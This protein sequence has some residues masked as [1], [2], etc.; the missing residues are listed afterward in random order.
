MLSLGVLQGCGN[1]LFY[2]PSTPETVHPDMR[3][4]SSTSGNQLA[5]RWLVTDSLNPKGIVLHFH[6]NSGHMD[7][8][9]EKVSWLTD[10][11]YHVLIFDYSGFGHSTGKARDEAM[12][13]DARSML[14]FSADVQKQSGLPLFVVGTSTGG[15]VF[16]RAWADQPIPLAGMIIDSSF[17]SYVDVAAF[18]LDQYWLGGS[19][20]WMADWLMR[21]DYAA[22]RAMPRLSSAPALVVHCVEDTVVPIRTSEQLFAQLPAT[23]PEALSEPYWGQADVR[24]RHQKDKQHKQF[25]RLDGCQHA[26]AMT[27]DFPYVQQQ[28]A[29]WLDEVSGQGSALAGESKDENRVEQ[30][31]EQAASDSE[32]SLTAHRENP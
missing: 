28:I 17:T 14:A 23:L 31:N 7:A 24:V 26:R 25:W 22:A 12:Y 21:D 13:H 6:G 18:T 16:L 8:T 9:Q 27:N 4:V 32:M 19:Y 15:N 5:T 20:A 11:G 30:I 29:A 1:R 10:Y 3:L 2:Y